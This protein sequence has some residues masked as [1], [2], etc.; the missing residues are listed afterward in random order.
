MSSWTS[1]E[2]IKILLELDKRKLPFRRYTFS[3]NDSG[4]H[5]L[6]R[7]ASAEVYGAET[8][9]GRRKNY[10]IKVIGF[11]ENNGDSEIFRKSVRI[12]EKVKEDEDDVVEIYD[13]VELWVIF[14]DMEEIVEVLLEKPEAVPERY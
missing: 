10:A 2:K 3:K 11:N 5:L 4:L 6:G 12:Q 7:G 9:N 14:D 8:R 1:E 13:S